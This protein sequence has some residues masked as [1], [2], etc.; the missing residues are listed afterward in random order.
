MIALIKT[1]HSQSINS[2]VFGVRDNKFHEHN[3]PMESGSRSKRRC[4]SHEGSCKTSSEKTPSTVGRAGRQVRP[5][6]ASWNADR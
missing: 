6:L 2:F 3:L 1:W 5:P 4:G